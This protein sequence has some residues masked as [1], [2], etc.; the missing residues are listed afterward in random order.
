M[1]AATFA[2]NSYMAAVVKWMKNKLKLHPG[3]VNTMAVKDSLG[4]VKNTE[5][6]ATDGLFQPP[7]IKQGKGVR[8][9]HFPYLFFLGCGLLAE[10]F[11]INFNCPNRSY[12]HATEHHSKTETLSCFT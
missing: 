2:R 10:E 6:P 8:Q 3:K 11:P 9:C 7:R 12:Q 5:V 1:G 4:L